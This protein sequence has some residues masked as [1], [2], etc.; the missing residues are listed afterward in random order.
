MENQPATT[1]AIHLN[2]NRLREEHAMDDLF[3]ILSNGRR[4]FVLYYLYHHDGRATLG[5][6]TDHLTAYETGA[7]TD[8]IDDDARQSVYIS[9]YQTHLPKL[10]EEGIVDYDRDEQA[11]ELTPGAAA[12]AERPPDEAPDHPWHRYLGAVG[13]VGVVGVALLSISPGAV[14]ETAWMALTL[15]VL[16]ALVAVASFQY[17]AERTATSS[18][19][20]YLSI[21]SLV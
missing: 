8:E 18:D 10:D 1:E 13:V 19:L 20:N 3:G 5:E 14:G 9:L 15:V 12:A 7:E 6:L 16:G 21:D 11:V 4:R 17:S 2:V